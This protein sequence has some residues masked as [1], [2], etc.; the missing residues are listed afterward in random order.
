MAMLVN[1]PAAA[2][3]IP[4]GERCSTPGAATVGLSALHASGALPPRAAY[5]APS[6]KGSS[7]RIVAEWT[8]THR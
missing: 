7:Q 8:T 2:A 5:A 4:A 3:T 1:N 6:C